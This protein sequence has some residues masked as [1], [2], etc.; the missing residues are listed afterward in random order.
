[1]IAR[2]LWQG[3]H[4]CITHPLVW[5]TFGADWADRFHDWTY[6]KGWPEAAA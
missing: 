1:M 6:T 2:W 4:H 3:V 5:L